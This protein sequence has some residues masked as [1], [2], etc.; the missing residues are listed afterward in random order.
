MTTEGS[1]YETIGPYKVLKVLGNGSF[2]QVSVAEHSETKEKVALKIIN[3]SSWNANNKLRRTKLLKREIRIANLLRHPNIIRM[4][5]TIQEGSDVILVM[6]HLSGGDLENFTYNQPNGH[7]A[8]DVA[9]PIFRQ[10]VSG[11]DYLHKNSITHRD[12][13]PANIMLDSYRV[14]KLID[15]GFTNIFDE[16]ER[17]KSFLGSPHFAAP[18]VLT[19]T[20]Y[21]GSALD[22][23][24]LGVTF[25]ACVA[26]KLPFQADNMDQLMK[27]IIKSK[28]DY[29]ETFSPEFISMLSIMLTTGFKNRATME[30][31]RSSTWINIDYD[32]LPFDGATSREESVKDINDYAFRSLASY[33]YD[34]PDENKLA[35]E[36]EGLKSVKNI[37]YLILDALERDQ[38]EKSQLIEDNKSSSKEDNLAT[39]PNNP[40][41]RRAS[42]VT[43]PKPRVR[44]TNSAAPDAIHRRTSDTFSSPR[45]VSRGYNG[46]V[47]NNIPAGTSTTTTTTS[48]YESTSGSNLSATDKRRSSILNRMATMFQS[49]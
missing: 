7:I 6:E 39:V 9:R 48:E 21:S 20:E 47:Y 32:E 24:S 16:D 22:V 5:G 30:K 10:V 37:Y 33:G 23:W 43:S 46:G 11:I 31:V 45:P 2:A 35:L 26:G 19:G 28:I 8:E 42:E 4:I 1:K 40:P 3:T 29:P 12:I 44:A 27:K 25:F 36:S 38:K 41:N 15:F 13:K 34:N 49:K 18:E 17:M 14:P